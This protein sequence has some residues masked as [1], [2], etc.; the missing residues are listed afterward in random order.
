MLREVETSLTCRHP[1]LRITADQIDQRPVAALAAAAREAQLLQLGSRGLGRGT[2]HLLGSVALFVA[3]C[4]E[5]PLVLVPVGVGRAVGQLP[6]SPGSAPEATRV[7]HGWK[8]L[9]RASDEQAEEALR[10]LS[11]TLDP[12]RDKCPGVEMIEEA[13]VGLAGSHLADAS[14]DAALGVV[15]RSRRHS[16]L[17]AHTGPAIHAVLRE[18]AAPDVV[19]PHD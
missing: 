9:S 1:G 14:R 16:A 8:Q 18:A 7:V 3:A 17:G 2:G 10:Q 12:W 6:Y 15:G 11:E 13:V 5:W 19:V 4:A